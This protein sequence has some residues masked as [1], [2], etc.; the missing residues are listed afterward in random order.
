MT[1]CISLPL[2]GIF[3]CNNFVP[4]HFLF[5]GLFFLSAGYYS[6]KI[7]NLMYEKKRFFPESDHAAIDLSYNL[8]YLMLGIILALIVSAVTLGTQFWLTPAIE[9]IAVFLNMN[10][11]SFINLSNPFY[12]SVH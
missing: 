3:D 6:Y 7:S 5:A 1:S 11:F 12:D 2:I 8:S 10:Y 9:W 4:L